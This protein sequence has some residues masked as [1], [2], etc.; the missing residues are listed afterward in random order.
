MCEE[1]GAAP[2]GSSRGDVVLLP[3]SALRLDDEASALIF[4]LTPIGAEVLAPLVEKAPVRLVAEVRAPHNVEELMLRP[5]ESYLDGAFPDPP[6]G[7]W[8]RRVSHDSP[9]GSRDSLAG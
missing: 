2:G 9:P 7:L 4:A 8:T 5:I 3:S 6:R 1:A